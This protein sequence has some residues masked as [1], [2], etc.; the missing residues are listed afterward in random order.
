LINAKAD[1]KFFFV[2]EPR[3]FE[4]M[5]RHKNHPQLAGIIIVLLTTGE[6][7]TA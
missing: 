3:T 2:T 5:K 4:I 1:L 7:F 6:E